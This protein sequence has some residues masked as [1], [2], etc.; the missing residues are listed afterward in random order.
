MKSSLFARWQL[1]PCP[2]FGAS[3]RFQPT[4]PFYARAFVPDQSRIAGLGF[5]TVQIGGYRPALFVIQK[6]GVSCDGR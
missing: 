2:V 3:F 1:K 6:H 4:S 5:V